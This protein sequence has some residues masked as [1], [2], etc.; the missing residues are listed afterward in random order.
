M[1]HNTHNP[2]QTLS[3]LNNSSTCREWRE[4]RID[5]KVSVICDARSQLRRRSISHLW[6]RGTKRAQLR[7]DVWRCAGDHFY[8]DSAAVRSQEDTG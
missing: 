1:L 5:N 7:E 2:L 8:R 6:I 4:R 3:E